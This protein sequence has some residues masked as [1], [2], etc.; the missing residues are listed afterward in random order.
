MNRSDL[1]SKAINECL[2]EMYSKAQPPMDF[3]ELNRKC[4]AKEEYD[5]D[6][7]SH[8]YLPQN[9]YEDI[10]ESYM[11]TYNI[12]CQWKDHSQIMINYLM[13]GGTKDK[14]IEGH[15]GEDGF[16][17]PGHRGYENTPKI[18]DLIG[19]DNAEK[20]RELME[21]CKNFYRFDREENQ[22][23]FTISNYAPSICKERV[24]EYWEKDGTPIYDRVIDPESEKWV[25]VTPEYI[26]QCKEWLT[27]DNKNYDEWLY[28]E[29]EKLVK[30]YD[31]N[32]QA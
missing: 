9:E 22:F 29:Y 20:V 11:D 25:T 13:E 23:R 32:Y 31:S 6:Y 26:E 14:W 28:N 27:E 24:M 10:L 16:K 17:Y 30:T 12:K 21:T 5:K 3:N 2:Q 15:T 18:S 1:L 19:V 8:H 4:E 7:W